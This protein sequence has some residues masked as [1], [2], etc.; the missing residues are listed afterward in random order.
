MPLIHKQLHSHRRRN[1]Q[2]RQAQPTVIE[3]IHRAAHQGDEAEVSR[4]VQEDG[5]STRRSKGTSRWITFIV[6]RG[7]PRSCWRL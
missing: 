2:Y 5:G 6:A 1:K 4:L 3:P 7:A